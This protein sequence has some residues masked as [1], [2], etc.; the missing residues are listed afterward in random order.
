MIMRV[1]ITTLATALGNCGLKAW[2]EGYTHTEIA[3]AE[4][5]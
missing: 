3:S 5:H 4:Q 2:M 1:S